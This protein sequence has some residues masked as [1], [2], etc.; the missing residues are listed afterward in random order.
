[1]EVDKAELLR[2]MERSFQHF[3]ELLSRVVLHDVDAP[4]VCGEW[5]VKDVVAHLIAHEQR[6]IDELRHA[7]R[8]EHLAIKHEENDS[9]NDG[10]VYACRAMPFEFVREQWRRSYERAAAMIESLDD[11]DFDAQSEIVRLLDD[12]INGAVANNTYEHHDY[13]GAQIAAWL[14]KD[15]PEL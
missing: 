14:S 3:D 5:S 8:G 11:A 12:S 15:R 4:G 6:T 1:M 2:R 10:A 9:F 7:K 13:H